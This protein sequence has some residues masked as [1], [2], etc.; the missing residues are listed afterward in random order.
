M[1]KELFQTE[2]EDVTVADVLRM[3]EQPSL[4]E[5]KRLPLALIALVDGLRF[6][7][8]NFFIRPLRRDAG[9][10]RIFSS[11]SMGRGIRQ[12]SV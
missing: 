5:W 2:D 8:T 12:D 7:V 4:P 11:I 1:W 3:L 9:R 6:V 10:H